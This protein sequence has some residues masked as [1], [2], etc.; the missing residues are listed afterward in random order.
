[1]NMPKD[2]FEE[3]IA[4]IR[5][6]MPGDQKWTLC[7]YSNMVSGVRLEIGCLAGLSTC[8]LALGM[9]DDDDELISVDTFSLRRL[10]E[11]D[12]SNWSYRVICEV[13]FRSEFDD[14]NFYEA[15]ETQIG[16]VNHRGLIR[17]VIG[18]RIEKIG[19]VKDVLAGRKISLLFIDGPHSREAITEELENYLELVERGGYVLFHD[20]NPAPPDD[21][22]CLAVSDY[23]G[24]GLL[25]AVEPGYLYVTQKT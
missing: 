25:K 5:G 10:G 16:M 17:A 12:I 9:N 24:R 2:E 13:L 15:W 6:I 19:E 20:Y 1:M 11:Q 3:A 18:D 23:I 22:A 14:D 4:G 7:R 21:G 8:C